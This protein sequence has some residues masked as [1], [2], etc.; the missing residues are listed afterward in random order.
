MQSWPGPG[1]PK[2]GTE[3][4]PRFREGSETQGSGKGPNSL[5]ISS[6]VGQEMGAT[7]L[8]ARGL[9]VKQVMVKRFQ[10]K[11]ECL[12]AQDQGQKGVMGDTKI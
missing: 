6:R 4:L 10:G 2:Q 7:V 11:Q 9:Q 5:V 12:A 3:I 1:E 8:L